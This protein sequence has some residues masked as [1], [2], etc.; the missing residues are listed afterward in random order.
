MGWDD[1]ATERTIHAISIRMLGQSRSRIEGQGSSEIM[2]MYGVRILALPTA[3]M[4]SLTADKLV[5]KNNQECG[6]LQVPILVQTPNPC[7]AP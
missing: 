6:L 1:N 3:S 7:R 5:M 4:V 2:R